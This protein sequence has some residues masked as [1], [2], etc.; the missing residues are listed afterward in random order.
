MKSLFQPE[1]YKEI[2]VR[3]A[4]LS[5]DTQPK[6]GSMSVSQMLHHCQKPLEVVLGKTT[7]EKPNFFMELLMKWFKGM[8][9]N[10]KPW[11]HGLPTAKEFIVT[12][13]KEFEEEKT[14]LK[15]LLEAFNQIDENENLP[16]HPI[17]GKFTNEQWGKMQ[18]KHL[19]HHFR[20][21]G[22]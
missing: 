9:Y 15:A 11:K 17:F 21:F 19:D 5:P 2:Q 6:W 4:A 18:Y 12:E 13:P 3:I 1:A 7:V 8:M 14:Q 16:P 20:Q 22:V 10:D